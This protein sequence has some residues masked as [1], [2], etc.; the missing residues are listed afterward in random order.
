[1]IGSCFLVF[2]YF[3]ICSSSFLLGSC[4]YPFFFSRSAIHNFNRFTSLHKT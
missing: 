4:Y 3:T 1:M 2:L